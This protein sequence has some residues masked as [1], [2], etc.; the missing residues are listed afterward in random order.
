MKEGLKILSWTRLTSTYSLFFCRFYFIGNIYEVCYSYTRVGVEHTTNYQLQT[1]FYHKGLPQYNLAKLMIV[2]QVLQGDLLWRF[3]GE[4]RSFEPPQEDTERM[5][6]LPKEKAKDAVMTLP[7]HESSLE[8][9]WHYFNSPMNVFLIPSISIV[10][11]FFVAL[12]HHLPYAS[13]FRLENM[14]THPQI[15]VCWDSFCETEKSMPMRCTNRWKWTKHQKEKENSN[16]SG[17]Q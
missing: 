17:T 9:F 8:W 4:W 7:S 10:L 15:F 3:G 11:P 13:E 16:N 1:Y 6:P 14:S 2:T 12:V 5:E